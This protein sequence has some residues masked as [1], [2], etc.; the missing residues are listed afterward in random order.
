MIII[1][2]SFAS[3]VFSKN[4]E[5]KDQRTKIVIVD[6]GLAYTMMSE[7]FLCKGKS[8]HKDFT[9]QGLN[10]LEGHGT[11][12]TH[13]VAKNIDYTKFCI[14]IVKWYHTGK[15]KNK[16][17]IPA[18]KFATSLNPALI[19]LSL[20]SEYNDKDESLILR[21]ALAN[22]VVIFTSAGNNGKNLDYDCNIYPACL[23]VTHPNMYAV[24]NAK[25][26]FGRLIYSW[27]SN[28]HGKAKYYADGNRVLSSIGLNKTY[29]LTGTSQSAA[30]LAN[31]YI[32]TVLTPQL[33]FQK[34][35]SAL[36]SHPQYTY[37]PSP[38]L[39]L[40]FHWPRRNLPLVL[41]K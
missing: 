32:K 4:R 23:K 10:D 36:R 11:H 9:G 12:I 24:A 28:K 3:S 17:Y 26:I 20:S 41:S 29:R 39:Q 2:L 1:I 19:N 35:N 40:I 15:E 14:S 6:T 22:G 31:R 5:F 7:Q 27:H 33:L 8:V 37:D 16:N 18:L 30:V 38:S 25:K 13:L 21:K 34:Q